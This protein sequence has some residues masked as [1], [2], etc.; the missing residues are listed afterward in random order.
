MSARI[1]H[2]FH[3]RRPI[4]RF[5]GE[6]STPCRDRDAGHHTR[7][8]SSSHIRRLRENRYVRGSVK[9]RKRHRKQCRRS[10]HDS[11]VRVDDHIRTG[12]PDCCDWRLTIK[13]ANNADQG[14]P[15]LSEVPV[16][17]NVFSDKSKEKDKTNLIVF[18]TPHIIRTKSDLRS[19]ALDERQQLVGSL[20]A[21]R[22]T[23]CLLPQI[24]ELY[25]P[26]FYLPVPPA[27]D[28]NA[29]Y[30]TPTDTEPAGL[31]VAPGTSHATR[32]RW[33][34]PVQRATTTGLFWSGVHPGAFGDP[35]V[36]PRCRPRSRRAFPGTQR[37]RAI[38]KSVVRSTSW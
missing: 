23:I 32:A 6:Y 2:L 28:L 4:Q 31:P 29:P 30:V 14:I 34:L 12:S 21:K 38:V 7:R 19:L 24:R 15:F 3:R 27:A 17:G 33:V 8:G 18:V 36:D 26:S 11:A 25:K 16:I 20:G 13:Q 5:R 22:F 10:H 1:C 9:R 35:Y 37:C